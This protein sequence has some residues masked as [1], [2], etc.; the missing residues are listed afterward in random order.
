MSSIQHGRNIPRRSD[1][2]KR[3][4]ST[5][6][7]VGFSALG[8][9]IAFGITVIVLNLMTYSPSGLVQ[10]YL[11]SLAKGKA[12]EAIAYPGIDLSDEN[13]QYATDASLA[14]IEQIEIASDIEGANGRHAVTASYVLID[15]DGN[16]HPG[17]TTFQVERGEK[18]YGLFD[19]W[20]FS[21]NPVATLEVTV[22]ND[23]RFNLNKQQVAITGG[24]PNE[25]QSVTVLVPNLYQVEHLSNYFSSTR[26]D[27][28]IANIGETL[29]ASLE[30]EPTSQFIDLISGELNEYLDQ[31]AT[32]TVLQP[33]GCPFGKYL[34]DTVVS[35]PVWSMSEYPEIV[36]ETS[37]EGWLIPAT[38]GAA[39]LEVRMKSIF[40][41]KEYTFNDTIGF[42]VS[43]LIQPDD[44]GNFRI[45][46]QLVG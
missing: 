43:Y 3:R 23:W 2:G 16:E 35:D 42:E 9:L 39:A 17:Q 37:E 18:I 19:E 5:L 32:Q 34:S 27:I 41:G 31:C 22:S 25:P 15:L 33:T 8:L 46:E 29:Q 45:I 6:K 24:Q 14:S 26:Q 4:S 7:W 38:S 21:A 20:A 11:N 36:F 1:S 10:S 44:T 13:K 40:D 28:A 12:S 30:L